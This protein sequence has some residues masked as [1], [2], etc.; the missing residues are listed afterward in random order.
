M[1]SSTA[2]G[3]QRGPWCSPGGE[4]NRGRARGPQ[5]GPRAPPT[6]PSGASHSDQSSYH[7]T[8][9]P[10]TRPHTPRIAFSRSGGRRLTPTGIPARARGGG[11]RRGPYRTNRG[12][13]GR[14]VAL[15]RLS[16]RSESRRGIPTLNLRAGRTGELWGGR[17]LRPRTL[18]A[19]GLPRGSGRGRSR[20]RRRAPGTRLP[21][22]PAGPG[23]PPERGPP[24][25]A[26]A[27]GAGSPGSPGVGSAAGGACGTSRRG[28]RGGGARVRA[29]G[30]GG[31]AG[32]GRGGAAGGSGARGARCGPRGRC[33]GRRRDLS[34][35]E[36]EEG[37]AAAPGEVPAGRAR[38]R[39][40]EG[41]GR[42]A[43]GEGGRGPGP[44]Q[45]APGPSW[46]L[47][48][49]LSCRPDLGRHGVC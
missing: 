11:L 7:G 36:S 28:D 14:F 2:V 32:S 15:G 20:A 31:P 39:S 35:G 46:E 40:R 37:R 10:Y 24:R 48:V 25:G 27:R 45:R 26:C 34:R 21:P 9:R 43:G 41:A 16:R 23:L 3:P 42:G 47:E 30:A 13:H 38:E 8:K 44:G 4:L 1:P 22:G 33:A 5:R 12:F 19:Q 6:R 49:P 29:A 17:R 18:R